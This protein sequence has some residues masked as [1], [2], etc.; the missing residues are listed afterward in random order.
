MAWT[1]IRL[2]DLRRGKLGFPSYHADIDE[3]RT[4]LNMALISLKP[5][6][7]SHFFFER[8]FSVPYH[9][10]PDVK[11]AVGCLTCDSR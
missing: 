9:M 7:L 11:L 6:M 8:Q 1:I 3:T 2:V 10:V 5:N 4:F